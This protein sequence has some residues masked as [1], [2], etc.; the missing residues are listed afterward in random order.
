MV[1]QLDQARERGLERGAQVGALLRLHHLVVRLRQLV[2][3]LQ[4][5]HVR[6][7]PLPQVLRDPGRGE[8]D[9]R[10]ALA[11]LR[12]LSRR[13]GRHAGVVGLALRSCAAT[14]MHSNAQRTCSVPTL[15]KCAGGR[16]VTP[17]GTHPTAKPCA[18]PVQLQQV[19]LQLDLQPVLC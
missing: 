8:R 5:A 19:L 12:T 10:S 2:H 17:T 7:R 3:R 13:H 16:I 9:M 6:G 18:G 11:S 14:V 4:V 1:A 15:C